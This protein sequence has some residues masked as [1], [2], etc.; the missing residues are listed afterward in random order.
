[1]RQPD[2]AALLVDIVL[3]AEDA[4][5]LSDGHTYE[6]YLGDLGLQLA[7]VKLVEI[8][9]EAAARLSPD[10]R[11]ATPDTPWADIIGMR[12]RLV[13]NYREID[14]LLVWRTVQGDIPAL[15]QTLRVRL[16]PA[17]PEP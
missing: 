11:G 1:M 3:A 9:G 2:D 4:A 7:L 10:L 6:S 17:S 5:R 8:I 16:P 13:H 14:L 12:H 15:A